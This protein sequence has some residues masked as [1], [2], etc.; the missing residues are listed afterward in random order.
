MR[1]LYIIF[2]LIIVF[3]CGKKESVMR[4]EKIK[5]EKTTLPS[6]VVSYREYNNK[7]YLGLMSFVS[8]KITPSIDKSYLE[9][10]SN[11]FD[12]FSLYRKNKLD[13]AVSLY[14]DIITNLK[15]E[16]EINFI[17]QRIGISLYKKGEF[18]NSFSILNNVLL[19]LE[20]EKIRNDELYYYLSL[21]NLYRNDLEVAYK[22]IK[23]SKSSLLT[24][25]NIGLNYLTAKIALWLSNTNEAV[26]HLNKAINFDKKQFE[27]R[28]DEEATVIFKNLYKSEKEENKESYKITFDLPAFY[29]QSKNI[30]YFYEM[31]SI[32]SRPII[33]RYR[34]Y[35]T[36]VISLQNKFY[37]FYE[38]FYFKN[39]TNS[40]ILLTAMPVKNISRIKEMQAK[41][42]FYATT[43]LVI[44]FDITKKTVIETNIVSNLIT[45]NNIELTNS[46]RVNLPFVY[47]WKT[48]KIEFNNDE[49]W[50][51]LIIGLNKTN[52]IVY[53]IFD[54]KVN[55]LTFV[56]TNYIRK[57]D[58]YLFVYDKNIKLID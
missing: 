32:I 1:K 7:F 48:E 38:D 47:L 23:L 2:I 57:Y 56:V 15:E 31:P 21:L 45:T 40:Y 36:N 41:E 43:P 52:E 13:K 37:C 26:T 17:N 55:G 50:D 34:T 4:E 33:N 16:E 29:N 54:P 27:K 10:L 3:G 42:L 12:T 30:E 39:E 25:D 5:E 28:Y 18:D 51:Y 58:S 44:T 53:A 14:K 35:I 6:S 9:A 11:E 24:L 46:Q 49:Y 8:N 20:K 19:S 22:L